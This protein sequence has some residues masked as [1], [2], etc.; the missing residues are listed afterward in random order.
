MENQIFVGGAMLASY[1]I[2]SF[3][4]GYLFGKILKGMDIR[5]HGSGNPGATNVFRVVGPTAGVLTLLIDFAKG[6]VAVVL[7]RIHLSHEPRLLALIGLCAILG[8]SFSLFLKFRGGKGVI[9]SAGVFFAILP[10]PTAI[11]LGIFL[12]ALLSTR[13]VSVGSISGAIGLCVS[14][15]IMLD[16]K[17]LIAVVTASSLLIIFLHRKN[18]QRLIH[19]QESRVP[20]WKK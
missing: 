2:G 3:P 6:F 11:A 14:A 20:L 10:I 1:L 16:S 8:H 15:W 13:Y 9:T 19:H 4:T 12:V 18:I 7:A 17:F 5:E